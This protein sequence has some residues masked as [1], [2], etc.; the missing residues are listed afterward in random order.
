MAIVSG[1]HEAGFVR[2]SPGNAERVDTVLT[3]Q[4]QS[5]YIST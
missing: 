1:C 4:A 5:M 2:A 3:R